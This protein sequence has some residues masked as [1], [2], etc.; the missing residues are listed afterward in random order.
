MAVR[1]SRGRFVKGSGGASGVK[2]VDKDRGYGALM[3]RLQ[4][5]AG[6]VTVGIHEDDGSHPHSGGGGTIAEVMSRHELGLGVPRRSFIADYVDENEQELQKK[7]TKI[8]HGLVDGTVASAE[9]G[10][11]RF[12]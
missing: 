1:D 5:R 2:V 8:G 10:L 6:R 9:Q 12:G 11:D 4:K 7:L 3:K